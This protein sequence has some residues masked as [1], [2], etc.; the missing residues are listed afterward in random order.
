M[1]QSPV[2]ALILAAG[3][4][5]RM[6]SDKAKVLHE[7][8]FAPMIHHVLDAVAPLG[9]DA[10]VVV[11]GH[12]REKVMSALADYRV[13]FACQDKQL[14]T[15]HAVLAARELLQAR[16]GTVLILCGDTPLI[17]TVTLRDM[18]AEHACSDAVL[19][20]MTTELD[21]PTNYGRIL[22][23]DRGGVQGIIE[24]KDASPVQRSIRE[25]NA[26]IYCVQVDFLFQALREVGTDNSQ[27][28]VYLT[29]IVGLAHRSAQQVRRFLCVDPEEVLGVNSRIELA[30]AG[31]RLRERRNR[32]LMAD[33][34]TL[35]Q[36]ETIAVEETVLVGN[37]T[38][39]E[40]HVRVTGAT[41]IGRDCLIESFCDIRACQI[42]DGVRI[43][44]FAYL[45]N[46][47]IPS[48]ETVPP[49][50]TVRGKLD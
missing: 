2:S 37:D 45:E 22:T 50:A 36:P 4:G 39:V 15:G 14:G 32:Q 33:G 49:R 6:K 11:I 1:S 16:G 12:Q 10:T 44:A 38:V 5:T 26:G 46:C 21:D 20:V 19:T 25:V 8:F 31:A 23:D 41:V 18:L 24:E 29:D 42:G 43:G 40:P 35:M 47:S 27:G 17:R 7:V 30:V 9:L 28:E 3:K 48:G 13:L 34:V